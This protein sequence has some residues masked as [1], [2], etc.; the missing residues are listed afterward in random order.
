MEKLK[1]GEFTAKAEPSLSSHGSFW[2]HLLRIKCSNNE[3]Q[4]FVHCGIRNDILSYST[5]NGTST[6]IVL[7]N[8]IN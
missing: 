3:Y 4:P 5:S 6:K 2:E 7:I 8:Q 1:N